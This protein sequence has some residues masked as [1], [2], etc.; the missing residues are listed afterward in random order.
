MGSSAA[1]SILALSYNPTFFAIVVVLSFI[2]ITLSDNKSEAFINARKEKGG[3]MGLFLSQIGSA[4]FS[5][6][7][8]VGVN[9]MSGTATA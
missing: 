5:V 2:S 7:T 8:M 6:L 9:A 4:F 3:S 1:S